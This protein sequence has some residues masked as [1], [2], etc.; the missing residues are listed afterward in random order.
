MN[1]ILI[2]AASVLLLWTQ[3][4]WAN[5]VTFLTEANTYSES[6]R[7][8]VLTGDGTVTV[9]LTNLFVNPV[10]V[11]QA[12]SAFSVDLSGSPG[13]LSL[14]S[15][16][17][18]EITVNRGG[19]V[20]DDGIVNNWWGSSSSS[21]YSIS[22]GTLDVS[23]L[24]DSKPKYTI[25]GPPDSSGYYSNANSSITGKTHN[26]FLNGE[27]DLTFSANGVTSDTTLSNPVFYFNTDG[28][29]QVPGSPVPEPA[30][31][32]LVGGVLLVWGLFARGKK[33]A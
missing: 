22:G 20:T 32:F 33:K 23:W 5:S 7:A 24:G 25:L 11:A 2:L 3:A 17:G 10:S 19:S 30:S 6:A 28:N 8:R 16:T 9:E 4:L 31:L 26:P 14:T 13:S 18:H 15:S 1:R 29:I 21:H 27:V 12:L